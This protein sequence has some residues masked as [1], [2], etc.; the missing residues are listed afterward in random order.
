MDKKM[1][2]DSTISLHKYIHYIIVH[3]FNIYFQILNYFFLFIR[4]F[5]WKYQQDT[6]YNNYTQCIDLLFYFILNI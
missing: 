6:P 4:F 2:E 5:L 1:F 3:Y